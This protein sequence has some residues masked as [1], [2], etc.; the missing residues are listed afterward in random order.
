[1]N[2][3]HDGISRRA[4]RTHEQVPVARSS[5][6]L[7]CLFVPST[8]RPSRISTARDVRR[9]LHVRFRDP[10][11]QTV[12]RPPRGVTVFAGRVDEPGA[13]GPQKRR[14]HFTPSHACGLFV[15]SRSLPPPMRRHAACSGCLLSARASLASKRR[16]GAP[17]GLSQ[18]GASREAKLLMVATLN[19]A[20]H[21]PPIE[22]SSLGR[23]VSVPVTPLVVMSRSA[24]RVAPRQ[25]RLC[26]ARACV[27]V[28]NFP[29]AG[30]AP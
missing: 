28:A 10:V 13:A 3:V 23:G 9:I 26:L 30:H 16:A 2:S 1:M 8:A 7:V 21:Q 14:R 5:W 20:Y 15:V 4:A 22:L 27:A 17:P 6:A 12:E 19:S 18:P 25:V 29:Q 11:L 24:Y